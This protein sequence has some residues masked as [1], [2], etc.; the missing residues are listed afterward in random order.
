M[1]LIS[2]LAK[3]NYVEISDQAFDGIPSEPLS[4]SQ[5]NPTGPTPND[6]PWGSWAA[7]GIWVISVL[8][9]IILPGIFLFPYI[10]S[11]G[12]EFIGSDD[13]KQFAE[14]DPTAVLL[15]LISLIP[16][17]LLTFAVVWPVVTKLRKYPFLKTLGWR[18]GGYRWWHFLGILIVVYVSMFVVGYFF[19]EQD[20]DITRMVHSSRAAAIFI[21]LIATFGAPIIEELI[22]R[23]LL[24]SAFQRSMGTIAAIAVVTLMFAGVHFPQYWDSPGALIAITILSL[25]LTL[26]R[27]TSGN[28]LPCIILHFIFN[29]LQSVDILQESARPAGPVE[30]AMSLF[31]NF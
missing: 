17:Y 10:S 23:G 5:E 28:L 12:L 7:L 22:Y 4:P 3:L 14:S 11:R 27:T 31:T 15:Q 30:Q 16:A 2:R 13:F 19:P 20:N 6:P 8:L 26:V 29:A 1:E 25:T 18:C 21:A 24:Y 9:I